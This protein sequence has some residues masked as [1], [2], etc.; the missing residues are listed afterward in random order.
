[1]KKAL[2]ISLIG[3]AVI[4]AVLAFNVTNLRAEGETS[5]AFHP[6]ITGIEG[7]VKVMGLKYSLW[8][9]AT[10][11]TLLLSGDMVKTGWG[12]RAE[13]RFLS[14][15]VQLYENS[16]LVI[17]SIGV[18]DR[19]KDIQEIVVEEGD[20][21]FDINPMG[22]ERQFEFRTRNIQGGVKGTVFTVSYVHDGTTVNV[23]EGT[24]WISEPGRERV[25]L[26]V[27]E[28]G[29][30]IRIESSRDFSSDV[31]GFDPD[32]NIEDYSYSVPPGLDSQS[33]L[34]AD[35]NADP[36]NNGVRTRGNEV[37]LENTKKT[38]PGQDK[39]D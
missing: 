37:S 33:R 32:Y 7:S 36:D 35:Y 13:V 2:K 39:K 10:E 18:Q 16:L 12:S 15:T 29:D 17:P 11:G 31:R 25:N 24:V 23:Y 26:K 22:V 27:L 20:V 3:A 9:P 19:K 5:S 6:V 34:P 4:S 28:A 30:A 38:P 14:G 1:M 21:L 8:E